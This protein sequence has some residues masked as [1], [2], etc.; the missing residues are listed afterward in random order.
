MKIKK[1]INIFGGP[2]SGKSVLAAELFTH[3]KKIGMNVELITEYAKM[4]TYEERRNILS[5]DQLYVFAK[6]HRKIFRVR[7]V[8]EYV[9]VDSPLLL[10]EIYFNDTNIYD[11]EMFKDFVQMTFNKYPNFNIYLQRNISLKYQEVG[12]N[13]NEVEA[14]EID[15]EVYKLL[16]DNNIRRTIWT[17]GYGSLDSIVERL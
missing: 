4:L 8:V 15:N 14:K 11:K 1:V 9:I 6:Q 16:E 7:N 2:G 12:R 5:E 13:Q 3:M 10:S 17:V